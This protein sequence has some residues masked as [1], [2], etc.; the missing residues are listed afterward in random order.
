MLNILYLDIFM[1]IY[2][3]PFHIYLYQSV[4][5]SGWEMGGILYLR[6]LIHKITISLHGNL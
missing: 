3:T 2:K 4:P 5:R 1:Y 6:R